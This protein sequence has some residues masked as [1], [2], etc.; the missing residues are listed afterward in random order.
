MISDLLGRVLTATTFL[1]NQGTWTSSTRIKVVHAS[2]RSDGRLISFLN[3]FTVTSHT[4][5]YTPSDSV[6]HENGLR[7]PS[8][9]RD[10]QLLAS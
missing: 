8:H 3:T 7:T 6:H 4:V 2:I 9:S 5:N 10:T 1:I